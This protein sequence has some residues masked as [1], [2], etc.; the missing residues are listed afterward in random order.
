MGKREKGWGGERRNGEER[1]GIGRREKGK[2]RREKGITRR[3]RTICT[4]ISIV[5][6]PK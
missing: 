2:G 4:C 3:K 5:H 1:E 6:Q